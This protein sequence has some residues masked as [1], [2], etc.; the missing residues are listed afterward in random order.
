MQP[1]TFIYA[2]LYGAGD[3]KIGDIINGSRQDGSDIKT[4]FFESL[5]LLKELID[6]VKEEGEEGYIIGLDGR[7]LWL[8]KDSKGRPMT[9]KALNLKLQ[10]AGAL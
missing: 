1:K 5:P 10:G 6:R 4:R 3:Q 7:K 8:R 9:H 2:F